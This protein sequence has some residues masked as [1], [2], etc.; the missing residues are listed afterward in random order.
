MDQINPYEISS[1]EMAA[2]LLAVRPGFTDRQLVAL[3]EMFAAPHGLRGAPAGQ[4]S[5]VLGNI[6][7]KLTKYF[8]KVPHPQYHLY[9]LA[10]QTRRGRATFWHLRENVVDALSRLGWFEQPRLAERNFD[11]GGRVALAR[12]VV[13]ELSNSA[14]K[15]LVVMAGAPSCEL[16]ASE[17]AK[18]MGWKHFIAANGAMGKIGRVF[19]EKLGHPDGL[20]A[21]EFEWWH[22]LA[23][24]RV[25]PERGFVWRLRPYVVE[26]LVSSTGAE[27]E[28]NSHAD[29][30]LEPPVGVEVP[31][32]RQVL[33]SE[34]QR[35]EAVKRWVL[36]NACGR[37]EA[38]GCSAPFVGKD[39]FPYLEVHHLKTL[40]TGGSDRVSNAVA[41]CPNCHRGL[42]H[43]ATASTV[44]D[45]IYLRLNRLIRE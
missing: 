25:E 15:L 31:A 22:V 28:G 35:D 42:H 40:A 45:E 26:A 1:E 30:S 19:Y 39:G 11:V 34:I 33:I 32:S 6:G 37:C 16:G 18:A 44:L 29:A 24:G 10:Y 13:S 36:R 17:V 38:C 21:G 14:R 20:D 8:G 3:A 23:T 9:W 7:G 41:L 43:G 4:Y 2:A 27:F 12:D 5:D